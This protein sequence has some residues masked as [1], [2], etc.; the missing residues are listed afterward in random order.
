MGIV[1]EYIRNLIVKQ[2]DDNGIV[3]WYDP[4]GA[5]AEAVSA[6]GPESHGGHGAVGFREVN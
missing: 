4:D 3:V 2:V 1:S 5:Y 6:A